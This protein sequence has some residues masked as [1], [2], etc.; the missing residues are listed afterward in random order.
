MFW[1]LYL[2]A[3][4]SCRL[5]ENRMRPDP[6]AAAPT[7]R[8]TGQPRF[9][10]TAAE[11][12]G[13]APARIAAPAYPAGAG[14]AGGSDTLSLWV[15]F[16][17]I[18]LAV[19]LLWVIGH[20]RGAA[21]AA[22]EPLAAMA[23]RLRTRRGALEERV[24]ELEQCT[25]E[26]FGAAAGNSNN[27]H[28][29]PAT[30]PPPATRRAGRH[31]TIDEQSAVP[32]F[33]PVKPHAPAEDA[34]AE[35]TPQPTTANSPATNA[36]GGDGTA[37]TNAPGS[38]TDGGAAAGDG[39]AS[40]NRVAV[41][42]CRRDDEC[43]FRVTFNNAELPKADALEDSPEAQKL[44]NAFTQYVADDATHVPVYGTA[45]IGAVD[46]KYVVRQIESLDT[47]VGHFIVVQ[48]SPDDANSAFF[49]KMMGLF[50][51]RFTFLH[52]PEVLSCSESWNVVL[53]LGFSIRPEPD[54]VWVFN[55]DLWALPGY[56][57]KFSQWLREAVAADPNLV[58][59]RFFHFSSFAMTKA[60]WRDM[61]PFDEVIYPAYA[62]DVEFH[63]RAVSLG[64]TLGAY[65]KHRPDVSAKHV[66]SRSFTDSE[67]NKK[68][69]RWDKNDYMFRKWGVDM[70]KYTDFQI[71][72]PFKHPFNLPEMS[73]R[74]SFVVD[75][76][77]R[78]CIKTGEGP[79][80]VAAAGRS[81]FLSSCRSCYYNASVLLHVMPPGHAPLPDSLLTQR[82]VKY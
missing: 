4:V 31:F 58:A 67:F 69:N 24:T 50:P 59:S 54:F 30:H 55:G 53:R 9:A 20:Q 34:G 44:L 37:T 15:L 47:G 48:N 10:K 14:G 43:N 64:K 12:R 7:T 40:P 2:V 66:G 76:V 63:L 5:S 68:Y 39:G 61:G 78:H 22:D 36:E 71:A 6:V 28:A 81:C 19:V 57:A 38:P 21:A 56:Q 26:Q 73:H 70:K 33:A 35:P 41:E 27:K 42:G 13:V 80:H 52:R 46:C 16:I 25:H 82:R 72:K 62:E 49:R 65:P 60:G 29:P 32:T 79:K 3:I 74:R 45:C 17:C 1:T 23:R 11:P 77:H 18:A 51:G 8:A 75:P